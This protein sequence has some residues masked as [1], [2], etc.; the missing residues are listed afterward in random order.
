MILDYKTKTILWMIR[1]RKYFETRSSSFQ[2]Q[3]ALDCRAMD[4]S[5][6][7]CLK[8]KDFQANTTKA[9]GLMWEDSDFSDVTLACEDGKQIRVHKL[10]LASSSEFFHNL[11]KTNQHSHPLIVMRGIKSEDL[12]SIV[13]F[14]YHGEVRIHQEN[15]DTFLT[16]AKELSLKGLPQ[17]DVQDQKYLK[18]TNDNIQ[19]QQVSKSVNV[20]V[21]DEN[22]PDEPDAPMSKID[23]TKKVSQPKLQGNMAGRVIPI[24]NDNLDNVD[25][26]VISMMIQSQSVTRSVKGRVEAGICRLYV[27]C[28]CGKEAKANAMK[29]HIEVNHIEGIIRPCSLCEMTFKTRR[30]LRIHLKKSHQISNV[31]KVDSD[32]L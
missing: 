17:V 20:P 18:N 3:L 16:T 32:S 2:L 5:E 28:V 9:F 23:G 15:L 4:T 21:Q 10:V 13:D 14:I 12:I 29:E 31:E 19:E 6:K 27:C 25:E 26:Q 1:R 22:D 24:F 7:L 30:Y 11:L 8:W